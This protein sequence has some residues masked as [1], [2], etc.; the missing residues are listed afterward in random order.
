MTPD[1]LSQLQLVDY[2]VQIHH[3][4]VFLNVADP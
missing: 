1:T 4:F 2:G 3:L